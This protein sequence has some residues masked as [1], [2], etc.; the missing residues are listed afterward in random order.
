MAGYSYKDK[1]GKAH[2]VSDEVTAKQYAAPGSAV[3]PYS[4]ASKGG[5]AT[6][7]TPIQ[8]AS[9][10]ASPAYIPPTNT[11]APVNVG[12]TAPQT[13]PAT[14]P[15]AQI[16]SLQ[17]Q[18]AAQYAK[19]GNWSDPVITALHDQ[20]VALQQGTGNVYN[21]ATGV[22]APA[23]ATPA[24]TPAP[25]QQVAQAPVPI[26]NFNTSAYNSPYQGQMKDVLSQI[27]AKQNSAVDI[28][29]SPFYAAMKAQA[30]KAGQEQ[31][32]GI[33]EEMNRRGILSSSQTAGEVSKA[34]QD[35]MTAVLPTI[36]QQA[37]GLKQDEISNLMTLLTQYG[38]METQAYNQFA[39]QQSNANQIAQYQYEA[40]VAQQQAQQKAEADAV[41]AEI[42]ARKAEL[43][44]A[45]DQI[46]LIGFVDNY[47]SQITGIPV[48]TKSFDAV[49]MITEEQTKLEIAQANI[50]KDIYQTDTSA[51]SSRYAS[52]T[53]RANALTADAGATYRAFIS[54]NKPSDGETAN[55][56]TGDAVTLINEALDAGYTRGQVESL[57]IN[58]TAQWKA[59]GVDIDFVKKYATNRPTAEEWAIENPQ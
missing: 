35:A 5:Y 56:V 26:P 4:G 23:A 34:E 12:A 18:A 14:S 39:G 48:G 49:K 37:Y 19:S 20:V 27:S 21:P 59:D 29:G 54:A 58:A 8:A 40:Q 46:K 31:S 47:T 51:A 42:E 11:Q 36:L 53:S 10:T 50:E 6:T 43:K 33:M 32:Q 7:P 38:N 22:W 13:Q 41:T 52:D 25:V 55:Q 44:D 15:A 16:A 57:L 45:Y 1:Y 2:V 28:E 17:A 3:T 9:Q 24:P 30:E